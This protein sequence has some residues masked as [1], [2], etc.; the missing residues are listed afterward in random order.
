MSVKNESIEGMDTYMNSPL[1]KTLPSKKILS[2]NNEILRIC[3][4]LQKSSNDIR[5]KVTHNSPE[6]IAFYAGVNALSKKVKT[7]LEQEY[8]FSGISKLTVGD[9]VNYRNIY[10]RLN[11]DSGKNGDCMIFVKNDHMCLENICVHTI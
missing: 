9:G 1:S 7:I 11:F 8:N 3:D 10:L 5:G 6:G 2:S 4:Y